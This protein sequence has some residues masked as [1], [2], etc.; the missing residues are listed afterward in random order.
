MR[1]QSTAKRDR[2]IAAATSRLDMAYRY[3]AAAIEEDRTLDHTDQIGMDLAIA[4]D[5]ASRARRRAQDGQSRARRA[6]RDMDRQISE[7]EASN[8]N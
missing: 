7:W 4:A 8:G 1:K 5:E 6:R 3:L 2:M